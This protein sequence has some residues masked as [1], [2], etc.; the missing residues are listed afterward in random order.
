MARTVGKYGTVIFIEHLESYNKK[1]LSYR[2]KIEILYLMLNNIYTL[3]VLMVFISST[4]IGQTP[5]SNLSEDANAEVSTTEVPKIGLALSGG[6]AHGL[7]HVGVIKYLEELEIP[8]DY[9]TGTSMGSI[10]GGLLAM[11]YSADEMTEIAKGIDWQE[12]LGNKIK[13]NDVAPLEKFY[14]E[15]FPILFTLKDKELILPSGIL[16]GQKLDMKLSRIFYPALSIDNFDDLVIP[17]RCVAV[18]IS[19]GEV[20]TLDSGYLGQAIRASMAIPMVFSPIDLDG[21]LLVDGGLIRNFPVEENRNMGADIVIG[22]YVGSLKESKENLKSSLDILIQSTQM[23]GLIDS[24]RQKELC[25]VLI[26]PKVKDYPTL[27]FDNSE[28]IIDAGYEAAKEQKEVLLQLKAKLAGRKIQDQED[29]IDAPSRMYVNKV[30][31]PKTEAPLSDILLNRCGLKSGSYIELDDIDRG[32]SQIYGTKNFENLNYIFTQNENGD[33]KLEINAD[34]VRKTEVGANFNRFSSTSSAIILY[35][36]IRNK[37][38]EPSRL[39]LLGRLSDNPAFKA[40]YF[41][42]FGHHRRLFFGATHFLDRYDQPIVLGESR[43]VFAF[44]NRETSI[45]LGYETDNFLKVE[46]SFGYIDQTFRNRIIEED[47]LT[48]SKQDQWRIRAAGSYS[49]LD[50]PSYPNQGINA[51]LRVETNISVTG[52]IIDPN[53]PDQVEDLDDFISIYA[54]AQYVHKISGNLTSL[55][56]GIGFFR[57]GMGTFNSLTAGGGEQSRFYNAPFIGWV[58]GELI[59]KSALVLRQ[60]LRVNPYNNLYV[61]AIANIAYGSY[62][63][64]QRRFGDERPPY[65]NITGG[66]GVKFGYESPMGPIDLDLGINSSGGSNAVFSL[67][68]RFIF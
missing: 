68:Y 29:K 34:P 67:G 6:A 8:V 9:I 52:Q 16:G 48:V 60:E 18:D 4:L 56:S 64:D 54:K 59:F 47:N 61:S 32:L 26:E 58:E 2:V 30:T 49:S 42:R 17:F 27:G 10:V 3:A 57:E 35:G 24:D 12:I 33:T 63:E 40:D 28:V 62:A 7:A 36:I 5:K 22:V 44:K 19:S 20:I 43:R 39:T 53:R 45:S 15:K 41:L 46:A 37:V 55:S 23:M 66:I 50:K 51:E 65:D 13:L 25:D 14:H 21:R 11:G 38:S 31:A 1:N